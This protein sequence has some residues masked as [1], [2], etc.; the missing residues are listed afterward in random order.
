MFRRA[1]ASAARE[2]L[3]LLGGE[4]CLQ[5]AVG[6]GTTVTLRVPSRGAS[7]QVASS[8]STHRALEGPSAPPAWQGGVNHGKIR[9]ILVDDHRIVREGIA[10][11]L[12]G[13]QDMDVVAQADDGA[14]AL[15]LVRQIHPDV[16]IM[17]VN[18][19]RM[20]GITTTWYIRQADPGVRVIGL[21][22][23]EEESMEQALIEAGA[24]AYL[25]KGGPA[26]DLLAA[27]RGGGRVPQPASPATST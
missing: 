3:E 26:E 19:P 5:S 21:S 20:D 23:Y 4:L 11:L 1:S 16:V 24:S 2:R 18:M 7:L 13:E 14:V 9:V 15:E 10:S 27:I 25:T 12:H 6:A 22:V 8:A 17:D